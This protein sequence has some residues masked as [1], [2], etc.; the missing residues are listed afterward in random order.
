MQ[1][2]AHRRACIQ[3][4]NRVLDHIGTH[5]VEPLDLQ[6]LAEVACFSPWHF[7]RIFQAL[8]GETLAGCVRRLRLE[9]AAQRLVNRPHE[10][11][12]NIA[13]DVGFA[14]AE[15]FTRAFKTH[16]GVTPGRW[17]RGAWRERA[18]QNQD[19]LR[20]IHQSNRKRD[21]AA[22]PALRDHALDRSAGPAQPEEERE[23]QLDIRNL[24]TQKL[25]YMRHTGPYGDAGIGHTWQRFGLWCAQ[26]GLMQSR[27]EMIG[28]SLDNPEITPASK[29]RYDCCVRVD[30]DFRPQGEVGV[31]HFAGGRYACAPF[32]GTTADIHAAWMKM[33]GEWLPQS[34]W[35]ADDRPAIE[36]YEEDFEMDPKTGAFDCLLCVPVRP[37]E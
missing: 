2:A 20:K 34:G 17:R 13:L 19:A 3:R 30:D 25:A 10:P 23:M 27:C 8:T 33:Y 16:F 36:L 21:Q 7:H 5:L 32:T 35:Q 24:S 14:S 26:H 29:L 9:A 11:A 1:H 6:S 31:Q 4:V 18:M 22:A 37:M 28:I 12:L 15:V